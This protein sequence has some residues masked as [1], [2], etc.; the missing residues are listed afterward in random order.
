MT[1]TGLEVFDKT[2]Q[3]THVWLNDIMDPLDAD[4]HLAW[5]VLAAVLQ[6]LRDRLPVEL[7]AHLG[8]QLP[9]IVRGAYYDQFTPARQPNDCDTPE[10]FMKAVADRL[11]D[12]SAVDPDDAIRTV[13]TV[14]DRHLTEGQMTKVR[15]ALPRG[16]RMAWDGAEARQL[17]EAGA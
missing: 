8:S 7:A 9:L 6:T 14:L 16:V 13:F 4:R 15:H 2:I 3:T 10:A 5:R 11:S 17:N 12:V 1:T